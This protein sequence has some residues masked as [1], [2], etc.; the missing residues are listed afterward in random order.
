[1]LQFSL[2][3]A[4][5]QLHWTDLYDKSVALIA[6]EEHTTSSKRYSKASRLLLAYCQ[7][8]NIK[9]TDLHRML[10]ES[11][12]E[13]SL[14]AVNKYLQGDRNLTAEFLFYAA[15]CLELTDDQKNA[16]LNAVIAD[17]VMGFMDEYHTV[18][19]QDEKLT[20]DKLAQRRASKPGS[21]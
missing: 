4:L 8:Q 13:W 11:G 21:R 5:P 3:V 18:V 14:S 6:N 20:A 1:M 15:K 10:Q 17:M 19:T 9:K 2:G 7:Q 16:L 12:S